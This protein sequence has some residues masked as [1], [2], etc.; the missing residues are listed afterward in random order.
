MLG[1]EENDFFWSKLFDL[2]E[3][4]KFV[5]EAFA[6]AVVE[7]MPEEEIS[8]SSFVAPHHLW[9]RLSAAEHKELGDHGMESSP[10]FWESFELLVLADV[11]DAFTQSLKLVEE[12]VKKEERK[13]RKFECPVCC[14]KFDEE[15]DV[16][17]HLDKCGID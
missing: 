12:T 8:D 1:L 9:L 13:T 10:E 3:A 7:C 6:D 17:R 2:V 14:K 5:D 11:P 15:L 4:G 16:I